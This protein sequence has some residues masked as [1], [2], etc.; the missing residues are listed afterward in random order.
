MALSTLTDYQTAL[1][2]VIDV[3][4]NSV[5]LDPESFVRRGRMPEDNKNQ[6]LQEYRVWDRS[7]PSRIDK[8]TITIH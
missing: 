5:G 6:I 4:K 2:Q 8:T 1:Y 7:Q 3:V